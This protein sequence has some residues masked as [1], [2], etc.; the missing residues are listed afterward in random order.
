MPFDASLMVAAER[1]RLVA[2]GLQ[3]GSDDTLGQG[4]LTLNAFTRHGVIADFG[5]DEADAAE[6][7]DACDALVAAGVGREEARTDRKVTNV[8]ALDAMFAGKSQRMAARAALTGARRRLVRVAGSEALIRSIDATLERTR[9]A[10]LDPDE[11]ATQLDQLRATFG[12]PGVSAVVRNAEA[13]TGGLATRADA[14][15]IAVG[16]AARPRGTPEETELVNLL[17]GVVVELVR[18]ARLAARAAAREL[19]QPAIARAFELSV[20][21]R[22]TGRR[23]APDP[24]PTPA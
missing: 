22:S 19:G 21:Y 20:L 11:L 10:G 1:R 24:S 3:F 18:A 2:V 6:L 15:R 12:L 13:L 9:S 16:Q 4:R 23:T 14:L 7:S 8:A 5:F 17:D